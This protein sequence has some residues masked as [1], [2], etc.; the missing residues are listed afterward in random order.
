MKNTKKI[1]LPG[2]AFFI[3][4][5]MLM[6]STVAGLV[7]ENTTMKTIDKQMYDLQQRLT[8]LDEG[9]NYLSYETIESFLGL[10]K[11][12]YSAGSFIAWIVLS[13]L[14]AILFPPVYIVGCIVALIIETYICLFV[15][16]D[17][18]AW[19]LMLPLIPL[20]PVVFLVW[21][22]NL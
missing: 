18:F 5:L 8:D 17:F 9:L 10:I 2:F 1:I 4:T 12:S 7:Q 20:W 21:L 3:A 6:T 13:V 11:E 14:F 16:F 22:F 19:L 15:Y